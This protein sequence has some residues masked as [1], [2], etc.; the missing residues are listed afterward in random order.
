M[1]NKDEGEFFWYV[2]PGTYTWGPGPVFADD[3]KYAPDSI[4][5]ALGVGFLPVPEVRPLRC[6]APLREHTGLFRTFAETEPNEEG[7]KDFADRFG[8]LSAAPLNRESLRKPRISATGKVVV[9]ALA[10]HAERMELWRGQIVAM[11]HAV[12]VWQRL[13]AG[14]HAK[15]AR[16]VSWERD[17]AGL[18]SVVFDTHPDLPPGAEPPAPDLR[19]REA[20]ADREHGAEWLAR[21]TPEEPALPAALW[22]GGLINRRLAG[23]VTAGFT[24]DTS[25]GLS[26]AFRPENLLQAMWLQFGLAVAGHKNYRRCSVCQDWFELSPELAR[27]NRRFC[28]SACKNRGFRGRQERARQLRS[29]GKSLR[30]IAEELHTSVPVIKRWVGKKKEGG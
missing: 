3:H 11:R 22:L 16:H 5:P 21:L 29:Q 4:P 30:E 18:R 13:G 7:A 9:I 2:Q 20:V 8:L 25:G 24:V 19:L 14:E 27:T 23:K 28:R 12:A 6:Y 15:L 10:P 26:L 17:A 1:A